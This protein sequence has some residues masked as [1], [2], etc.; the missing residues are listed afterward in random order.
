[1]DR[2]RIKTDQRAIRHIQFLQ[3]I[4][5]SH[6]VIHRRPTH[7]AE[8]SERN[9]LTDSGF[10]FVRG[11]LLFLFGLVTPDSR[12][13]TPALQRTS[14]TL[15]DC[16][17]RSRSPGSRSTPPLQSRGLTRRNACASG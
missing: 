17:S 3:V 4:C 16:P 13:P 8:A 7:E 10:S 14:R 15:R 1:F 11:Q 5:C 12:L 9:D 2:L 6:T